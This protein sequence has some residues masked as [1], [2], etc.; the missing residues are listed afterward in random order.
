MAENRGNKRQLGA[1]PEESPS[2][3]LAMLIGGLALIV[4]AMIAIAAFA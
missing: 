4:I 2:S 3:L 1:A